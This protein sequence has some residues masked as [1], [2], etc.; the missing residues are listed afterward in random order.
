MDYE[1]E[2]S[3]LRIKNTEHNIL[4]LQLKEDIEN[5]T[6]KFDKLSEELHNGLI[7]KK[8]DEA[9]ERRVG[10]WLLAAIGSSLSTG[11]IGFL[12]G[13]FFGG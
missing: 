12:A 10:K 2:I 11:I 6:K 9:L 7:K 13:K 1:K 5:L 4:L 3:D 8:V